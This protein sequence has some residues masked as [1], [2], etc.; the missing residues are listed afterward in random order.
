MA[1]TTIWSVDAIGTAAPIEPVELEYWTPQPILGFLVGLRHAIDEAQ[2]SGQSRCYLI[3]RPD[4][5]FKLRDGS[6]LEVTSP[7][8][9]TTAI[10]PVD[11]FVEAIELFEQDIRAW[12]E[13]RAP[14]LVR[15]PSWAEWFPKHEL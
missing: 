11:E 6:R 3:E 15:H 7:N 13:G 5:T 8:G 1:L 10:A 12:L 2:R 9:T 14:Q 4:L